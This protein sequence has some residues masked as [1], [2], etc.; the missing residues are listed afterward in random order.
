MVGGICGRLSRKGAKMA[1]PFRDLLKNMPKERL[2]QIDKRKNEVLQEITI[3][4]LRQVYKCT[5]K[6]LGEML[7]I[8]QAAI[9][10]MENQSDMY[11]STLRRLLEAMG[12]RLKIVAEFPEGEV[13]ITQFSDDDAPEKVDA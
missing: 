12:A 9:S 11:I 3:R 2:Q 4:D 13:V 8:N 7:R 10:K 6:Q 5:Q 1:K